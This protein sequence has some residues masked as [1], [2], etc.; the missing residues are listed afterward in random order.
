MTI[1]IIIMEAIKIKFMKTINRKFFVAYFLKGNETLCI[2]HQ[3]KN[4]YANPMCL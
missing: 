4:H 3:V 1:K 2:L